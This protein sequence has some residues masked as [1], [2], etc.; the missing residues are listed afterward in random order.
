MGNVYVLK[1]VAWEFRIP[2]SV[3]EKGLLRVYS[4]KWLT[5]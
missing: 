4:M 1:T 2:E 5:H 3:I